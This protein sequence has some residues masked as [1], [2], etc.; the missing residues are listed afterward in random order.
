M[1]MPWFLNYLILDIVILLC[2]FKNDEGEPRV[3]IL[4]LLRI[5]FSLL[6]VMLVEQ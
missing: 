4:N 1:A 6:N 2:S 5:Y 3:H